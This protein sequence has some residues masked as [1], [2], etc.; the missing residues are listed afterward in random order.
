MESIEL[1]ESLETLQTTDYM[2]ILSTINENLVKN[3]EFLEK[4]QILLQSYTIPI[5]LIIFS[6][7]LLVALSMFKD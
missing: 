6:V 5:F 3:N 4:I 1:M 2:E 7:A